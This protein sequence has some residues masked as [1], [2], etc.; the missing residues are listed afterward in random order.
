MDLSDDRPRAG[1]TAAAAKPFKVFISYRRGDTAGQ[2]RLLHRDL[3]D[4]FGAESVFMDVVGI[5]AGAN[6]ERVI[7]ERVAS[8]SILIALIGP[9]WATIAEERARG[10]LL[11]HEEDYV[12]IEIEAGLARSS[13]VRVIPV[14]VDDAEPPS[15]ST[16]AR[17]L[18]QLGLIQA[19]TLRHAEWDDD[20]EHLVERIQRAASEPAEE[21]E[22][23]PEPP[24]RPAP[25]PVRS[26][27][28]LDAVAPMP[29]SGH[30]ESV[31]DLIASEG[32]VVP[33][34]GSGVNW[35]D[36]DQPWEE[37]SGHLPDAQELAAHLARRFNYAGDF[38]DLAHIAQYV[39]LT[40]GKVDL[41]K[42]LR[43]I[44]A[45]ESPPGSIHRFLAG[46]PA[47]LQELDLPGQYDH[48]MI[49]TT[50]YDDA[51]ERAFDEAQERYDLAVYMASGEHK[52]RFLHVPYEGEPRA[53]DVPNEYVDFPIDEYGELERTVIVKIHGAVDNARRPYPWRENYV[54]TENDYIDYLS[55]RPVESL[56]PFQ[57]LNKMRESHFLFLGYTMGDWNLRV[58][59][60][61]VWGEQKLGAKSWA[62]HR[63]PDPLEKE[64]WAGLG[65]DLFS[66]PLAEYI[67]ELREHLAAHGNARVQS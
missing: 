29:D 15:A 56:V 59:L 24:P 46:L 43:R 26:E 33:V 53:I 61:R 41:Y 10:R 60:Q 7:R 38:S 57:I 23:P 62:I 19:V 47:M 54:I 12:R 67:D 34:L 55:Q 63:D 6:F 2:A 5:E 35:G 37:G 51:L 1:N 50:N 8:C 49:V 25:R 20:V 3:S 42:T 27:P 21:P 17:P 28:R 13:G 32:A 45:T 58:F 16:L 48:Q 9:R 64:F 40:R 30:Y 31:V 39:F 4:R 18:R 36:R 14:L 66:V 44:L 65:V 52:G 22:P 11:E